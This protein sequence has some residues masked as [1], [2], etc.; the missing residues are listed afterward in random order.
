M[1]TPWLVQPFGPWTLVAT[2]GPGAPEPNNWPRA[3]ADAAARHGPHA[4]TL[5]KR[6]TTAGQ[7]I[8]MGELV[9]HPKGLHSVGHGLSASAHRFPE[10]VDGAMGGVAA[11][12]TDVI[13]GLDEPRGAFGL[14]QWCLEARLRGARILA[15]PDVIWASGDAPMPIARQDLFGFIERF[16][17][18]PFAP[19]M[20]AIATAP[21]AAPLR[22][23]ARFFGSQQPFD[24][25]SERGAFH[26]KAFAENE[27]FRT[28]AEF[29][30]KLAHQVFAN[31][32]PE[33]PVLDVGC[34]DG[35]YAQ[36][37]AE[38]SLPVIGIDDDAI[39]IAEA[40]DMVKARPVR[41]QFERGTAY[42]L[43]FPDD[44]ARGAMLLDVIEHLH[45]P[46]KAIR[47][48]ARVITPGGTLVV[49]TP[50]WQFGHMSDPIYHAHEFTQPELQRLL[51]AEGFF[52]VERTARIGGIYR[53][54]VVVARRTAAPVP[55]LGEP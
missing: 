19:D 8:A 24:K 10:E 38:T 6:V 16:G 32:A 34:G 49:S 54:I 55:R 3:M 44:S 20:D 7:L 40:I 1:A 31:A 35:L 11:F 37:L 36:L 29:L 41:A 9:V 22:W 45:N 47:E 13:Q 30:V 15:V 21:E 28:R 42:A 51:T 23:N 39:G 50:E 26:W 53:D 14:L 4:V 17:F 46:A 2:G 52:A 18:H 27:S 43:R 5:C 48:L 12:P 33:A 25:Y